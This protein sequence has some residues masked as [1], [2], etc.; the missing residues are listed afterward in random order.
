[1]IRGARGTK[2]FFVE[3]VGPS[4]YDDDGYVIQW[5]RAFAPS[6][7]LACLF[8]L[9]QDAGERRVLGPDVEIVTHAYDERHTRIPVRRIIRRIAANEG[10]GVV[11]LVGVQSNQFPRAADLARAFRAAG[12]QVAIGGFHVSGCQAMFADVSPEIKEVQALGVAIFAG[13]AEGRID[14]LLAD[15]YRGSMR[16]MY[17]Y[18]G[19]PPELQGSVTPVL[20]R[21]L[22]RRSMF[23]ASFDAGRGCPFEC[24]FCA[25]INVQGHRS[26][27][28]TA[29]DVER[30]VRANL[31][32]G[33]KRFFITDDNLSRNKNWEA[34]FDRLIELRETEGIRLKLT[35]QV[36]AMAHTVPGFIARAARAGCKRVFIGLENI[37]PE[38]LAAANKR[39]NKVSEYRAMLQAWRS[40][41]VITYAGYVLGFPADTP[42][43]IE[44]DIRTIQQELPIDILEFFVLTPFPG[45]ADHK[46]LREGGV[47]MDP[48]LNKYD[49]EHVTTHH[50]RMSEREWQSAYAAAWHLYYTPE[51]VETLLRRARAMGAGTGHVASAIL[52]YYGSYRLE[53]LHALQCGLVRRKVRA[54][55]RPG[56]PKENPLLFYPRRVGETLAIYVALGWYALRL[57]RLRRRIEKDP[58]AAKYTDRAL[59]P[60]TPVGF[61]ARGWRCR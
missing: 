32:C 22:A 51:H 30:L 57:E 13:E 11:F 52:S 60:E 37:R 56:M 20:P 59:S 38:N 43:S 31:A 50:G 36:D 19:D 42:E 14:G 49:V 18:L 41:G 46:A 44:H 29:D 26:R 10:R 16:A 40:V 25:I 21:A 7:S 47:W 58:S 15:A 5:L 34:I 24:S 45:S 27:W 33:A 55:R 23:Y 9:V 28:R 12:V 1:M 39:Q 17:D 48:D 2:K 6:N 61:V 53:H 4:R 3:I 35:M 54:T 8:A